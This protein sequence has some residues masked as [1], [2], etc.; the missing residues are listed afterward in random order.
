MDGLGAAERA[1]IPG[2][3]LAVV[4]F[5]SIEDRI[6]KRFFQDRAGHG[7]GGSR[8]APEAASK[9]AQFTLPSRKPVAADAAERAENPRARSARLRLGRRTDAAPGHS[10]PAALGM[11]RLKRER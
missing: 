9:P 2:G 10:D 5:H 1:L 11:P 6:V 4:T 3:H 8:H 7:G